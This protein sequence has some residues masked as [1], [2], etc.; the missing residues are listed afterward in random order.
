MILVTLAM[1]LVA[2]DGQ[3]VP[4]DRPGV[5]LAT[6]EWLARE[7]MR[8]A[9]AAAAVEL[10]KALE[11]APQKGEVPPRSLYMPILDEL[12]PPSALRAEQQGLVRLSCTLTVKGTLEGCAMA[13]SSGVPAL[14][15]AAF[16]VAKY[17]RYSPWIVDRVPQARQVT[18]P[19]RWVIAG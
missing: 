5:A 19:V 13:V 17:A 14:D 16:E 18:F 2:P 6:A 8:R 1:A 10:P 9:D 12:Y 7:R 3:Q 11:A 4:S 15:E